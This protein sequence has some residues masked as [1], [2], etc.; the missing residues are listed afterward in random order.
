[1]LLPLLASLALAQHADQIP[2]ARLMQPD[3]LNQILSA[4]D[5]EKPLIIHVGFHKLYSQAHI[6]GSEYLGPGSSDEGLQALRKRV[7]KL[8]RDKFIVLYCGCCPWGHCPNVQP[9]DAALQALGFKNVKVL[10]IANNLGAD[11]VDKGYPISKGD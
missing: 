4:K 10:Y 1:M 11:W 5:G 8:P 7:E 2:A 3:A 9:A 6:P